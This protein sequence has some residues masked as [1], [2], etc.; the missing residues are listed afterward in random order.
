MTYNI[1]NIPKDIRKE[2]ILYVNKPETTDLVCKN[3]KSD[4]YEVVKPKIL[5][6]VYTSSLSG[7]E[8]KKYE[9]LLENSHGTSHFIQE[10][11]KLKKLRVNSFVH[12]SYGLGEDIL[13]LVEDETEKYNAFF[14]RVIEKNIEL[15]STE[16]QSYDPI[17]K[18]FSSQKASPIKKF[19][20]SLSCF[21]KPSQ[22]NVKITSLYLSH[23]EFSVFNPKIV[24][25]KDLKQLDIS[26]NVIAVIP[27]S[28]NKLSKLEFLNVSKNKIIEFPDISGITKLDTL[29]IKENK[30]KTLP[31]GIEKLQELTW[32][33]ASFNQLSF[34]PDLKNMKKLKSALL[35][36]NNLTEFPKELLEMPQL[37]N[38][39]LRGNP[40]KSIPPNLKEK[41]P[42][43]N[44]LIDG[45]NC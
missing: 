6:L 38:I 24:H 16:K 18:Q 20:D 25:M 14:K 8:Q 10:I 39:D 35:R 41:L 2:I 9:K 5:R 33:D 4:L 22:E 32:I 37:K 21:F 15:P 28:I 36:N 3:W 19:T 42:N 11:H 13:R 7:N 30:L 23:G 40:I 29:L 26:D 31:K 1:I 45:Y 44:I 34:L 27:S 17:F 43:T 12:T